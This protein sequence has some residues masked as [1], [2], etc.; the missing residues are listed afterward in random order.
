VWVIAGTQA[1]QAADEALRAQGVEV[2]RVA[3][4]SSRLDLAAVLTLLAGRGVT[5]LMV[6]GGPTLAAA[7]V[8]ADLVDEA[9]LF[10]SP[11]IIGVDGV[12]ALE[13]LPLRALTQSPRL[14]RIGSEAVGS[15]RREVFERK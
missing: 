8:A 3:E 2:L 10:H 9:V 11:K 5:R 15:D 4:R 12:D 7:L 1:P 14:K 13:G 6:E